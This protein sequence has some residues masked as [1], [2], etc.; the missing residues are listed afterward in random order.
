MN[1]YYPSSADDEQQELAAV[2]LPDEALDALLAGDATAWRATLPAEVQFAARMVG[3]LRSAD[4]P[5]AQAHAAGG[6]VAAEDERDDAVF[7]R[8]PVDE[9]RGSGRWWR[10]R[11]PGVAR[12]HR[13]GRGLL[14]VGA[15]A[16]VVA[17]LVVVLQVA[18]P[19]REGYLPPSPT[20]AVTA[21]APV[22]LPGGAWQQIALPTRSAIQGDYAVS[23][24]DPATIYAC[25]SDATPNLESGQTFPG[26][27]GV[28]VTHDTG[29][30]W[31]TVGLPT[32]NGASCLVTVAR[33]DPSRVGVLVGG[34]GNARQACDTDSIYLSDDGGTHW[35]S[36]PYQPASPSGVFNTWCVLTVTSDAL[37]V[38]ASWLTGEPANGG[39]QLSS[40][41]RT[42]D[43][44]QTWQRLD[45][46][47]GADALFETAEIGAGDDFVADVTHMPGE[48]DH[49]LWITH[50]GGSHWQRLGALPAAVGLFVL[51]PPAHALRDASASHPYYA[52][53]A[54][55][56]PSYLLRLA[57]YAS[58]D[59]RT[60]AQVP[61]LPV[62]GA[63][64]QRPGMTQVLGVDTAGR[65]YAFGVDSQNGVPPQSTYQ[66]PGPS[67][68]RQW[69][70]VWDPSAARWEQFPTPLAAP[71]PQMCGTPCWSGTV[72][73]GPDGASYLWVGLLHSDAEP[74]AQLFRVLV[75]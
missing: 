71:W 2:E 73:A 59:G 33:G 38:E 15:M 13:R 53:R 19:L 43:N 50:D 23:P 45:H 10:P 12:G 37:Y 7:I 32:L 49:A 75:R 20:Q 18:A 64:D 69:L 58:A 55:Q 4:S 21:R 26:T 56:I 60:W 17:V 27:I 1:G 57:A 61:P 8:E 28:W 11:R 24:T 47:F 22:T 25:F 30:H 51:P 41:Q 74:S 63:T 6:A 70:W 29:H 68:S 14:A 31:S 67:P 62:P 40:W 46:A 39:L 36:I 72:S 5:A 65:L 66:A 9:P 34:V 35:R 42:T 52:L 54:D 44:G 3:V 16:A 48:G